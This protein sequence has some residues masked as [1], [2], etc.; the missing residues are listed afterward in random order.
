[1]QELA[2]AGDFCPNEA[3]PDYGKLQD[4]QTQ[5]NLR[6][7]GKTKSGVQRYQCKRCGQTFTETKGTIFYRKRTPEHE[8]LE[9]LALLA[10]GNRIS[11]LSRVK[12][13]KEDTILAWLR[14]AAQHSAQVEEVLLSEFEVKRGQLDAL[15]A[16]I[17]NKGEKKLSRDR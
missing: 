1:M 13:F 9:T 6:R 16:Y 17:G 11:S 15:W 5:R 2:R 8:L 4:G 12:G 10:E 3:C 7:F 14:E